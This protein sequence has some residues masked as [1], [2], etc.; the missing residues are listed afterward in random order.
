MRWRKLRADLAAMRGRLALMTLALAISVTGFGIVLGARTVV[1]REI[2]TSYL[3]SKPAD[4]TLELSGDA[5]AVT[6]IVRARPEIADVDVR[7]VVMARVKSSASPAVQAHMAAH[8]YVDASSWKPL[9]LFVVDDF[10]AVKLNLFRSEAGAW[11]PSTGTMLVERSA[12]SLVGELGTIVTVRTPH[13]APQT[14]AIS[15]VVHDT[16]LAPAWQEH[17]GYGYITRATLVALGE[18]NILHELRVR[19][20]SASSQAEVERAARALAAELPVPV[21]QLRVPYVHRHPHQ[22]QME[23]AQFALLVFS[24]LLLGLCAILIST[25]LSAMLA[26]QIR[27]IGVMK[28][29]GAS[30]G[31]LAAVYA[32]LI[33]VIGMVAYAIALPLAYA[34]A[35]GMIDGIGDGL[36]LALEDRSIPSWVFV[37]QGLAAIGGP[38]VLSI[39]PIRRAC[40]Q[41]VRAALSQHGTRSE[42]IRVSRLPLAARNAMRQ[43]ARLALTLGLLATGGAL[44]TTAFNIK[45]AY[46]ATIARMPQ[47]WHYDLELRMAEPESVALAGTLAALPEVSAVEPWGFASAAFVKPGELELVHTYPDQAHGSFPI[48]GVPPATTLATLPLVAGRWLRSDD[49][50]AIVVSQTAMLAVGARP[51]L[52]FDGVTSTWTVVGVVDVLPAAGGFVTDAAFARV[53]HTEGRAR[54]FRVGFRGAN[55]PKALAAIE[56]ALD[57]DHATIETSLT[58][59]TLRSAMDDHVMVIA[60]AA[61]VLAV[62]VALIGLFGLAT[63]T[64]VNVLERTRELGMMKAMGATDRRIMRLV[65]GE[66][67]YT[68]FASWLIT[69]VLSLPLTAHLIAL[70]GRQGFISGRY[71]ISVAALVVS[72]AVTA[73]GSVLAAW[74]PARRAAKLTVREA[75]SD[76]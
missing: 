72:L 62:I 35:H 32:T 7:E 46:E 18:P 14:I 57:R 50:D 2:A 53:S 64:S 23:T 38:L 55:T 39:L 29:I 66:A 45:R 12:V 71:A 61:L 51:T 52:S 27:E 49:I 74:L 11:P 17:K 42:W 58:Y 9:Q 47:M 28:A 19:F 41:T 63:I 13:G 10:S 5:T 22:S 25:I 20:R 26:R 56:A 67:A 15:G 76:F 4:A 34:G 37:V 59:A 60:S 44:A 16:G 24:V 30:T 70:L 3:G 43:P 8:G 75:L 40:R 6:S 1:Q 65:L 68:G 31:Q 48:F 69:I 33:G 54:T 36:N 73:L 21:V